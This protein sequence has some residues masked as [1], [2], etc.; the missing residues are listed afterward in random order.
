MV[1]NQACFFCS[2]YWYGIAW[3]RMGI[4]YGSMVIPKRKIWRLWNYQYDDCYSYDYSKH[5]HLTYMK[6]LNNDHD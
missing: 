4:P 1:E 2:N 5:H 6:N 3:A